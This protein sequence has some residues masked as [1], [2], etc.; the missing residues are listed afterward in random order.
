MAWTNIERLDESRIQESANVLGRAFLD[1]PLYLHLLPSLGDRQDRLPWLMQ[2]GLGYGLQWGEVFATA[3]TVQGSA[4]WLPPGESI[5]HP[6]RLM[7]LVAEGPGRL[8]EDAFERFVR[9]MMLGQRLHHDAMPEPHWYLML[10][11]V[12][13]ALQGQG[14]G[15]ALLAPML[16]RID[17]ARLPCYL[18][19]TNHRN[20]D[21]YL[22]HGFEVVTE[23]HID[24][25]D[26]P[27]IWTM[28]REPRRLMEV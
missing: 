17:A 3:G 9:F 26:G 19:T 23:M 4:V 12:E 16:T 1:D 6:D 28:R 2:F 18:E 7:D 5:I 27:K 11:G 21:F 10:L 14:L 8:G 13:P 24:E 20:L 25:E 22:E 15:S